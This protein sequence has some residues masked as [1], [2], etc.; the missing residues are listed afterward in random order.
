MLVA[1]LEGRWGVRWVLRGVSGAARWWGAGRGGRGRE[2]LRSPVP[3]WTPP[4]LHAHTLDDRSFDS[5]HSEQVCFIRCGCLTPLSPAHD[6]HEQDS[7]PPT[8]P[9]PPA[10]AALL[11][12]ASSLLHESSIL[13]V[14][15]RAR[16]DL[17]S[18][19]PQP[20]HS[21]GRIYHPAEPRRLVVGQRRAARRGSLS[22][23]QNPGQERS[24][25]LLH[26]P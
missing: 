12:Y 14:Q 24:H 3:L 19:H 2:Q 5:N 18:P 9:P 10:Y 15:L 26:R 17:R 7:F 13:S 21:R 4:L 23:R 6:S 22:A 8:S 25:R 20:P 16:H 1:G 11:L